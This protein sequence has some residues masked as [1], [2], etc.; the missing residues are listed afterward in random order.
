MTNLLLIILVLF[1]LDNTHVQIDRSEEGKWSAKVTMFRAVNP[2]E[3]GRSIV[4]DWAFRM[5]GNLVVFTIYLLVVFFAM[6]YL[7]AKVLEA[8]D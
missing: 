2:C 3:K 6:L 1:L 5:L 8:I 7:L 4:S